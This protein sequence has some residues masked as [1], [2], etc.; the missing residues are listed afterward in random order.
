[1]KPSY[2][3][4]IYAVFKIQCKNFEFKIQD[5][6]MESVNKYSLSLSEPLSNKKCPYLGYQIRYFISVV[7]S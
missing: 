6:E 4:E 5:H 2:F 3:S 1:M 7:F